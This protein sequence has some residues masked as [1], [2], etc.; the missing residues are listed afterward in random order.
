MYVRMYVCMYVCAKEPHHL[1]VALQTSRIRTHTCTYTHA[2]MSDRS[3]HS[4]QK[5]YQTQQGTPFF[6]HQNTKAQNNT[7]E[8]DHRQ[9]QQEQFVESKCFFLVM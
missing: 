7:H 5:H 4:L 3:R 6:L 9:V 1:H 2:R 8:S